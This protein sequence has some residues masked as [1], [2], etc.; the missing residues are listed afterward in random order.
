MKTVTKVKFILIVISTL[1]LAS[2][3]WLHPGPQRKAEKKQE[4]EAKAADKE[5]KNARKDHIKKQNKE[6]RKMMK[7]SRKK[8]ERLNSP[9]KRSTLFPKKCL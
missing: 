5:F 8:A 4:Q 9:K 6:T 2:C 1:L 3:S 7:K